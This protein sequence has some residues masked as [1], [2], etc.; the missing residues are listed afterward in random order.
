[1]GF[2]LARPL[3]E[4]VNPLCAFRRFFEI[5]QLAVRLRVQ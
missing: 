3:C 1:M 4:G 5:E 2:D